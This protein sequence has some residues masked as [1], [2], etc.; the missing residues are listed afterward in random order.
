MNATV[1]LRE[2]QYFYDGHP[3]LAREVALALA[4]LESRFAGLVDTHG[5]V[6]AGY[7][8]GAT[9]GALALPLMPGLFSRA[10]LIEGGDGGWGLRAARIFKAQG[11]VRVLFACGRSSCAANARRSAGYLEKES[12]E[13]QVLYAGGAGHTYGGLVE[14]VV[15]DSFEWLVEGDSRWLAPQ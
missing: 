11:G 3:K 13:A 15:R 12:V 2:G 1:P 5:A 6:Y 14:Q 8:Q 4:A 10:L 9:M 7:S